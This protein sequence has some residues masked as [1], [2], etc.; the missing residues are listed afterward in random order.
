MRRNKQS[1]FLL[2]IAVATASIIALA[3]F[4]VADREDGPFVFTA[5]EED[6]HVAEDYPRAPDLEVNIQTGNELL[7]HGPDDPHA[8]TEYISVQWSEYAREY[9]ESNRADHVIEKLWAY[10]SVGNAAAMIYVATAYEECIQLLS[11]RALRSESNETEFHDICPEFSKEDAL[12]Y[13]AAHDMIIRAADH[14]SH[15]A[16]LIIELRGREAFESVRQQLSYVSD[17]KPREALALRH[18]SLRS[19]RNEKPDPQVIKE[20][21]DIVGAEALTLL[22]DADAVIVD[23][24]LAERWSSAGAKLAISYAHCDHGFDCGPG[25]RSWDIHCQSMGFACREDLSLMENIERR[26]DASTAREFSERR[27]D[28]ADI[29]SSEAWGRLFRD[30]D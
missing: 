2:I 15:I 16:Q 18:Q 9:W 22:A 26:I 7:S 6:E 1:L 27:D 23:S 30:A 28:L 14:G 5:S 11:M 12:R 17:G 19:A 21:A 10:A 24:L 29:V 4:F 8:D 25:T 20:L 13:E 3:G